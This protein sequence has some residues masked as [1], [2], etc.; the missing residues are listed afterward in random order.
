M[1]KFLAGKLLALIPTLLGVT[2]VAFGLIRLVPGDPIEIMMG[3]RKLD[4]EQHAALMQRLGLDQPLHLQYF[5]YLGKLAQGDLG[6]SLVTREPVSA[7]FLARYP[8]TLELAFMALLFAVSIGPM[9]SLTAC[10][11]S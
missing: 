7:E 9:T 6:Q 5:D 4:A 3:E 8:A 1:L 11:M 10:G 2:L